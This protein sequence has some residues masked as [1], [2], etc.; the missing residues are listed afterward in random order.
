MMIVIV[1]IDILLIIASR[2]INVSDEKYILLAQS[3]PN[4][5]I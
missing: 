3:P 5:I 1:I 2:M 4:I